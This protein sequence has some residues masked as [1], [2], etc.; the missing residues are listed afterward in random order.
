MK[1]KEIAF[2][3]LHALIYFIDLQF[4]SFLLSFLVVEVYLY[5]CER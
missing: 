3:V 4:D 1:R 2:R 5:S